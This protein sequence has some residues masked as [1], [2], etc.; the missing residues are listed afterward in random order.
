VRSS[1]HCKLVPLSQFSAVTQA[2]TR[3]G[4][5][6]TAAESAE[7][8]A[9]TAAAA[10]QTAATTAQAA[11]NT[12]TDAEAAVTQ[13]EAAFTLATQA[14]QAVVTAKSAVQSAI[15]SVNVVIA[16]TEAAETAAADAVEALAAAE[17]A[18]AAAVGGEVLA[19]GSTPRF[20][21][22][23]S[24]DLTINMVKTNPAHVIGQTIGYFTDLTASSGT[25]HKEMK[26]EPEYPKYNNQAEY[27]LV[28]IWKL[29][30]DGV[31]ECNGDTRLP[32]GG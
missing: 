14:E 1:L 11:A 31:D 29:S 30:Y 12:A 23:G 6:V 24:T 21:N 28:T 5:A 10:A 27:E 16:A 19:L 9:I 17:T 18:A 26:L 25:D 4:E 22:M 20:A 32:S 2:A 15:N 3:V 7:S 8:A 13:A